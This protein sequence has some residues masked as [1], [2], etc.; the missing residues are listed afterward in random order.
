MRK[1][2]KIAL[3]L[4]SSFLLLSGY[5]SSS[6][7]EA[8]SVPPSILLDSYPLPF[9]AD[10][11]VIQGTTMVPFRAIAEAM[12]IS[13][14]WQAKTQSIVATKSIDGVNQTII[15]RM[16]SKTATVNGKSQP[17]TVAPLSHGGSVLVPLSFF[18]SQFGAT[19][20]WDAKTR[21][22]A[23]TSPKED[24]YT[25]GFY[26]ISSYDER[27][28]INQLDSVSFGWARIDA[29]GQLT[30]Q[31]KDFYWPPSAGETTPESIITSASAIGTSPEL[32][33]VSTDGKGELTKILEDSTL[34]ASTI[35][36]IVELAAEKQFEGITLDFEGLGLT[37]DA[38]KVQ[39][40]FT[41]FVRLL[42]EKA[43]PRNLK[44]TLAL[45]P[46]NS[47]YKGYDYKKL[48]AYA[49][50]IVIMAY[51]YTYTKGP[52]PMKKVDEAIVMALK[53]VPKNKLVLGISLDSENPDTVNA[54]IGLAKRYDLKG[55][56]FWRI[57]II[58]EPVMQRMQQSLIF[59]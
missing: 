54:K 55:V 33:V 47:S 1:S 56:A 32:M 5:G 41:E 35:D 46:L 39:H 48:A 7:A 45:H 43:T 12:Q 15:L 57:G 27:R 37:G 40:S 25:L 6:K 3:I 49:D 14:E 44:L 19:V 2:R 9:P 50:Q 24:L 26:A 31:G 17:L 23:I 8:A 30:L 59:K 36:S 53:Q 42:D 34:R 10:P 28:F 11:I 58:G 4:C 52:E 51:D 21:T 29:G 16:K 18:S 13:V 38:A 22:V 20:S